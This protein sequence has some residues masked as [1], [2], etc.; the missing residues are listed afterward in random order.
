M[1]VS[2]TG[3]I[4]SM[5]AAAG[6]NVHFGVYLPGIEP[7]AGYAVRVLVI[8]ERDRFAAGVP[9]ISFDLSRVAG[10]PD[11][12]WSA[13]AAIS[14]RTDG[15]HLGTPGTYVYRYTLLRDGQTVTE[16][17]TDP[18]ARAT[19]DVGQLSAF[20][21]PDQATPFAWSDDS[22][23]V[24]D[25][26]HL[27]VY[28]MHVGQFN[29]SF[30]GVVDRIPYLRSLGVTCIEL[31]PV[32]SVS[33]EVDWGYGP[34]HHF[35]P[36]HR[37]GGGDGLKRLVDACHAAGIAVILDVVYQHVDRA[38]PYH[39][40]YA[41]AG[42]PSPM[43][44]ADGP[45]GP[46]VDYGKQFA[47][48]YVRAA[49]MHWLTEYHVDGF[50]YDEVTD[51]YD[52]PT[53]QAYAAIAYDV[54]DE[55]LGMPRFTP[56]GGRNGGEYSRVIQV[57]EA[58]GK[59]K[60]VLA[61]TYT[62]AAW[63]DDLLNKAEAMAQYRFADDE[64][65]NL[66]DASP[67]TGYPLTKSVHDVN[68]NAVDMPVAPFQ[69]VES[70]DHSQLIAFVDTTLDATFAD[71]GLWYR[72]QPFAIALL[73]AQGVPM[74]W[75]GQ[76]FADDHVLPGSGDLRIHFLRDTHWEYF[77]DDAGRALVRL[78]RIL[79]RLRADHPSLR[80]RQ[81]YYFDQLGTTGQGVVVYKRESISPAE[82]ALVF[83]NFSDQDRI[84]TMNFPAAGTYREMIDR[85]QSTP[86]PDITVAGPDQPQSVV[87]PSNYGRIYIA[88]P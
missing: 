52:G 39:L 74:L 75:E 64:F 48:D 32:S 8:H 85:D 60:Q 76:E 18:F 37:W 65:A 66:L 11:G 53:G 1:D 9:P 45:F 62:S 7:D 13:D 82:I 58:L 87:V 17:F 70:H 44:G 30:D 77:Y 81:S 59:A 71:R 88:Q 22:W 69:Y 67:R 43:I 24:P 19:D 6:V 54:Y 31:M 20:T 61:N 23:K 80:S 35:A 42:L 34:L 4:A 26:E 84:V 14:R 28:E 46:G 38:F 57:A 41:D 40:V 12:L 5:P 50:R 21:T 49:N 36:N 25:L 47:R 68:G 73:T 29:N 10:D 83:L 79:G 56:S 72:L 3:A 16:W 63:Q 2:K 78:Y 55:S 33:T 86:P 51:L 27:V 15:S